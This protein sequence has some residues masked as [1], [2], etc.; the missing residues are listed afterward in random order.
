MYC[1]NGIRKKKT[2]RLRK[3]KHRKNGSRR[4]TAIRRLKKRWTHAG[5]R[6]TRKYI[7]GTR[8]ISK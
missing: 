6:K 7:M 8:T 5:Q 2:K 3:G 4:K 1:G